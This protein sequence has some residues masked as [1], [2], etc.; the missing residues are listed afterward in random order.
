[1]KIGKKVTLEENWY[2]MNRYTIPIQSKIGYGL[3]NHTWYLICST[4]WNIEMIEF[5]KHENWK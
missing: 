3:C 2:F 1:M 4:K 5:Y